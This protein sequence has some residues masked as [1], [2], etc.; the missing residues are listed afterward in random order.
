MGFRKL[1]SALL[2]SVA[3]AQCGGSGPSSPSSSSSLN[4]TFQGLASDSSGRL[5][6]LALT[7]TQSGSSVSGQAVADKGV[8]TPTG[9]TT[10]VW[11]RGSL[12]GSFSGSTL[13]FTISVPAGGVADFPSCTITLNGSA[14]RQTFG[15]GPTALNGTYSGTTSCVGALS[16]GRFFV[17][18]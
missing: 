9:N 5:D 8:A 1:L 18:R 15:T 4:G 7:L 11:F 14:E 6:F 3:V 10:R 12:S 13:T 16:N 17:S 2:L